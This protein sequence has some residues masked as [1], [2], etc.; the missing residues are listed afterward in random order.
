VN[1]VFCANYDLY[2]YDP[3]GCTVFVS[4]G[5]R[6]MCI[7]NTGKVELTLHV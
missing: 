6:A 7:M 3:V 2:D 5:T 1:L 4:D